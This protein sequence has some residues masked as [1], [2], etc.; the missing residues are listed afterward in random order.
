MSK[1]KTH[2]KKLFNPNYLGSWSIPE[3]KD[4][5]LTITKFGTENITS[6]QNPKGEICPVCYF[7]ESDKPL[8]LNTT[9]GRVIAKIYGNYT[10]DWINKKIQLYSKEVKAFGDLVEAIRVRPFAP[11][12]DDGKSALKKQIREALA[13]CPKDK[14]EGFKESLNTAVESGADTIEFYNHI[15]MKINE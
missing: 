15:L 14:V 12:P 2:W 7:K 4:L 6:A 8:V 11:K 5:I 1:E 9:N 10:E 3:G 13:K